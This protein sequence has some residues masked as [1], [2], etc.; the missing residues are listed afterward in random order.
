[1]SGTEEQRRRRLLAGYTAYGESV[2]AIVVVDV[3]VTAIQVEVVRVVT[4]VRRRG[5]V[6]AVRTLIVRR[7]IV[8]VP[9]IDKRNPVLGVLTISED[10]L[11]SQAA[12]GQLV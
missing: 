8:V 3:R 2:V 5:P 7:A 10:D 4:I 11:V 12:R 1:M 9:G 6:V